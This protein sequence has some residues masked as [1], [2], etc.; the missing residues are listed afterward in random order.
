MRFSAYVVLFF[1]FVIA[2]PRTWGEEPP[3]EIVGTW[4]AFHDEDPD[5]EAPV[6]TLIFYPDGTL[7][8]KG[9][10]HPGLSFR[11]VEGQV[12]FLLHMDNEQKVITSREFLLEADVLKLKNSE[13]G[14]VHYR[15]SKD[16]LPPLPGASAAPEPYAFGPI[17]FQKPGNWEAVEQTG[18]MGSQVM[19]HKQDSSAQLM[20]TYLIQDGIEDLAMET[21]A[22]ETAL[23]LADRLGLPKENVKV[24]EGPFYD[25][26]GPYISILNEVQGNKIEIKVKAILL[27][28]GRLVAI[29]TMCIAGSPDQATLETI[30]PTLQ[31]NGK[32]LH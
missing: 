8:I 14:F 16:P 18:A 15:R 2:G 21:I 24:A 25:L 4:I 5:A 31:I 1:A 30:F 28:P 23:S 12:E 7:K 19:I 6:E 20:V 29:N 26:D 9:K 32:P 3:A 13:K 27:E 10:P 11:V 17:S 22:R